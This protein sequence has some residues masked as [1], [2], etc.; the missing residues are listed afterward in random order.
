VP[1]MSAEPCTVSSVG[2]AVLL[3]DLLGTYSD[4]GNAEVL[5]Q[6]LRW[7]GI[8]A[9][10]VPVTAD[11]TPPTRCELYLLGGGEDAGQDAAQVWLGRHPALITALRESAVTLAVCAGLQLLGVHRTGVDGLVRPGAGV[12]DL[13]TRPGA[14]RTIGEAVS[15]SVLPRVGRL[16]GFHNHRGVTTQGEDARPLAHVLAGPGNRPHDDAEGALSP[17]PTDGPGVVAT[18]LHGPVLARNPALADHL[19]A[20]AVGGLPL[21]DPDRVPDL[22]AL[23][24]SYLADRPAPLR[25]AVPTRARSRWCPI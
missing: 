11:T 18:Y 3:P 5:A 24:R 7:R 13:K 20:R 17:G 22:P 1:L 16:T 10:I 19:L 4:I 9:R 6:R 12:L 14:R 21:L 2:I 15:D 23:R 8:Q 25:H